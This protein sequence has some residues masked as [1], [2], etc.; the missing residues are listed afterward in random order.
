MVVLISLP[1]LLTETFFAEVNLYDVH[2][3]RHHIIGLAGSDGENLEEAIDLK[4]IDSA[5]MVKHVGYLDCITETVLNLPNI[6]C[7]KETDLCSNIASTYC[8]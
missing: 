4:N 6:F 8:N 7:G 2:Y 3:N 1:V 5:I